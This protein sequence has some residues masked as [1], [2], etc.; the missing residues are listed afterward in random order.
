MTCIVK[1][2][3][4]SSNGGNMHGII[5][6]VCWETRWCGD[7]S[8]CAR[9]WIWGRAFESHTGPV[10]HAGVMVTRLSAILHHTWPV[11]H[12]G[13]VVVCLSALLSHTGPVHHAG[14]VAACHSALLSHTGPVHHACLVV[15]RHS[16]FLSH[17]CRVHYD[18]LTMA[19]HS[20]LLCQPMVAKIKH[21]T[22]N[23]LLINWRIV[24]R[25]H[26]S[27]KICTWEQVKMSHKC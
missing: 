20:A 2:A 22:E 13:V 4:D 3:C 18:G 9:I 11:H 12:P 16:V 17:G 21:K 24:K 23:E 7:N 1:L 10:Y 6:L 8:Y 26:I 5:S 25:E 19:H 27:C 14:L 15:S